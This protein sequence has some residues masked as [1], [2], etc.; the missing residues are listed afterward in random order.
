MKKILCVLFVV[1]VTFVNLFFTVRSNNEIVA[2]ISLQSE[3]FAGYDENSGG[4]KGILRRYA[5]GIP[6]KVIVGYDHNGNAVFT[7]TIREGE[8]GSC[9][10][11]VG[12][13][14]P[15]PCTRRW[16]F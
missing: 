3:A 9:E 16:P 8:L 6:E 12:H 13:C 15:Y 7:E 14:S 1:F 2:L 5:C 11:Y 10:G 4:T